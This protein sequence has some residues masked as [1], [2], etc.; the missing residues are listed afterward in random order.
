MF[1]WICPQCGR[2]VPPSY[3]ECPDC[4]A[5]A[6]QAAAAATPPEAEQPAGPPPPR[7]QPSQAAQP[8][9][10]PP[11][12][13]PP[14]YYAPPPQAPP[15]YYPPP[16]H[17]PKPGM[18]LPI[19]LMTILFAF[20]IG[21]LVGG[22]IWLVSANRG[23]AGSGPTPAAVVE[24]PAA[25]PGTKASPFQKFIEVSGVRFTQDPK[26]KHT[27][28]KFVIINHSQTDVSGLS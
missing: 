22:M 4:A 5:R 13:A 18:N 24:S 19:W 20:A 15:A 21:G 11:P 7:G 26:T 17:A 3:T 12:Q 2:E 1:T 6:K 16:P 27:L 9:V 28:A 25:K 8:Y 10:P 23:G 14:A